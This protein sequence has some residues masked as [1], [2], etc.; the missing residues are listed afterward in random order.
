MGTK[1]WG[2]YVPPAPPN[3]KKGIARIRQSPFLLL[4]T[5]ALTPDPAGLVVPIAMHIARATRNDRNS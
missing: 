4:P 3:K 5:Q 2:D 1:F